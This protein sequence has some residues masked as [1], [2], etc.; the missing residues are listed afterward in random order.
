MT[1]D[2]S[3]QYRTGDSSLFS[4]PNM[5]HICT[6]EESINRLYE[7]VQGGIGIGISTSEL[8]NTIY[9]IR[10]DYTENNGI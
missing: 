2:S 4:L 3:D 8:L 7:D 10:N 1:T 6:Q 9:E 5:S